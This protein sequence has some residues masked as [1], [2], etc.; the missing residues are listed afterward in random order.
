MHIDVIDRIDVFR[1]LRANWDSVYSADSEAQFFLSWIWLSQL[2]IRR[3]DE[4]LVLAAKRKSTDTYYVAFFPLRP[5]TRFSKSKKKEVHEIYMAGNFWADYTGYI[6]QPA[7]DTLALRGFAKFV[8]SMNWSRLQLENI[9]SSRRRLQA[10]TNEFSATD[11]RTTRRNRTSSIDGVDNL[12]CP[13]VNLPSDFDRYLGD[14]LSATTRQK[15]RRYLR[16]LDSSDDACIVEST[17]E[18]R[19]RDLDAIVSFWE[20]R[21]AERKGKKVGLLAKKYR[22]ILEQ[23]LEDSILHMP[24]MLLRGVPIAAH[25][26]Y[27]DAEKRSLLFFIAG[28]DP[29]GSAMPVG[30]LLHAHSIR[31]AIERGYK[32]YELLRGNEKYKYSLGAIE[33]FVSCIR[34]ERR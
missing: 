26:S 21:W 10:F 9:R 20:A 28:R 5:R 8:K 13:I 22:R 27:V 12:I 18:T 3:P 7:D 11:F 16:K 2:F 30:L 24:V 4:W 15:I 32:T 33:T 34:I 17:V 31:W 29:S 6:C 14:Q 25:A 19:D 1:A 23:G